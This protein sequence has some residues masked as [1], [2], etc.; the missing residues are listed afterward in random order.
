MKLTRI[1]EGAF[2]RSSFIQDIASAISGTWGNSGNLFYLGKIG[3]SFL[4]SG[5]S[6]TNPSSSNPAFC[7][8]SIDGS[9]V[10]S[11]FLDKAQTVNLSGSIKLA[12]VIFQ[13][14]EQ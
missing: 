10:R 7:W 4:Y 11:L 9:S 12:I 8:Y 14:L 3:I 6:V 5:N 13:H 2:S 1:F